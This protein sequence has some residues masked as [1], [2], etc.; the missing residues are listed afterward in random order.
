MDPNTYK[1]K[2]EIAPFVVLWIESV[3]RDLTME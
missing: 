1:K 3:K 2:K